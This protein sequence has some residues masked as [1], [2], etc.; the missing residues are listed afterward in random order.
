LWL[1]SSDVL[2]DAVSIHGLAQS[3]KPTFFQEE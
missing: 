3:I 2:R 1:I